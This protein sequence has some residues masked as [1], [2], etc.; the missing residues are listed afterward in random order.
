MYC[1]S[2][3]AEDQ[4]KSQYCRGCGT[5][6]RR[7]RTAI[8]QPDSVTQSAMTAREE[9]GRAVAAKIREMDRARDLRH[10]VEEILPQIEKFLESPEERRQRQQREGMITGF[11]G[12]GL[13]ALFGITALA[14]IDGPIAIGSHSIT[15]ALALIGC[16]AGAL[17]LLI[18]VGITLVSFMH[19]KS[20]KMLSNSTVDTARQLSSPPGLT[21]VISSGSTS[22]V[23]EP[24]TVPSS[25]TESTTRQLNADRE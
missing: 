2:C 4:Q 20:R 7:V 25:V 16:G 11:V 24:R 8:E 9:I 12:L 6:L 23:D 10:A 1:P 15:A 18:G 17:V 14:T 13:I 5:E 3:G 21:D 22:R 19:S